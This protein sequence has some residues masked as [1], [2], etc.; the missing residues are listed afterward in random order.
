MC[1]CP[2]AFHG[3]LGVDGGV[4]A[5]AGHGSD[6]AVV[7]PCK[8]YATHSGRLFMKVATQAMEVIA[9]LSEVSSPC[10]FLGVSKGGHTG[11]GSDHCA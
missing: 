3:F 6:I 2:S 9:V 5:H 1:E 10:G 8:V 7:T 11:H 4:A